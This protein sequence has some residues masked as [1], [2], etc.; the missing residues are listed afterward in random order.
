LFPLSTAGQQEL[1][2]E[3]AGEQVVSSRK[4]Y[5]IKFAPTEMNEFAWAGE[6]LIDEEEFQ[7]VSVGCVANSGVAMSCSFARCH[8]LN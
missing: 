4:A 7:P 1:K 2:F 6:A 8:G 3:L 5:R